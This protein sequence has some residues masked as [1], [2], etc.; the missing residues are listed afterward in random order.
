MTEFDV[1]DLFLLVCSSAE[2]DDDDLAV[3]V[4]GEETPTPPPRGKNAGEPSV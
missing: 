3:D 1:E 4:A 2:A